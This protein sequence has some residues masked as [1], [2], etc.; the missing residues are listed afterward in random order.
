MALRTLDDT[1]QSD[2]RLVVTNLPTALTCWRRHLESTIHTPIE[3]MTDVSLVLVLDDLIRHLHLERDRRRILGA[4]AIEYLD[5][6]LQ[7][8]QVTS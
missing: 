8:E 3:K 1:T 5:G 4:S 7:R 2:I 6:L